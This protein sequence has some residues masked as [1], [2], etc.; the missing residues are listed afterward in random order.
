M[1]QSVKGCV[2]AFGPCLGGVVP[3]LIA[4]IIVTQFVTRVVHLTVDVDRN[5]DVLP[6]FVVHRGVVWTWSTSIRPISRQNR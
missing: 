3:L 1:Y 4:N 2:L 5:F 6:D